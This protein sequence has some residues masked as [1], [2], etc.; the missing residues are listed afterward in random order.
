MKKICWCLCLMLLISA[1]HNS[2]SKLSNVNWDT[3][4]GDPG[5]QHYYPLVQIDRDNV[6]NLEEVWRYRSGESTS[7][8]YTS[9]LIVNGVLYGLSP[10][11]DVFALNAA[12]GKEL[13]R[14]ELG[15][16][17]RAQRGLM[18]WQDGEDRRILFTA[19]SQLIA[20]NADSGR[21]VASFG[22][23]GKLDL[24]PSMEGRGGIDVTV[25][26]VIY[27]DKVIL[28]FSTSE[29]SLAFPGTVRAFNIID[30]SLEW[31]FHSIPLP[32]QPGFV[33]SRVG[34]AGCRVGRPRRPCPIRCPWVGRNAPRCAWP[35]AQAF[36]PLR[37]SERIVFAQWR[38][39]RWWTRGPHCWKRRS[40]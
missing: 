38:G 20:I 2:D 28:G 6:A 31:T 26:G 19:G 27:Q 34:P 3:Y 32:G 16:S 13:W 9:P 30:G 36:L 4:L 11:L 5:R 23:E 15:L 7:L 35:A 25:P 14:N 17:G 18:W 29:N 37:P 10:S 8:M 1:C 39:P 33:R 12:S 40:F 24:T 22:D 21:L